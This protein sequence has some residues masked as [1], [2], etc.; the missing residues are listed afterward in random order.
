MA[1]SK[2][3]SWTMVLVVVAVVINTCTFEMNLQGT[4][5]C[6][7]GYRYT[8]PYPTQMLKTCLPRNL[9][10]ILTILVVC[11]L[12]M[13]PVGGAPVDSYEDATDWYRERE[14][15]MVVRTL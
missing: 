5:K 14:Q 2:W 9:A 15:M 4:M 3:L 12:A 7:C 1:P 10:V 11:I 6:L 8:T 13:T